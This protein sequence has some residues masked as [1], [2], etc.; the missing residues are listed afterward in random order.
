MSKLILVL[1]VLFTLAGCASPGMSGSSIPE[2]A[3][4]RS[5]GG[6]GTSTYGVD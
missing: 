2:D 3:P 4:A 1:S 5:G 6:E